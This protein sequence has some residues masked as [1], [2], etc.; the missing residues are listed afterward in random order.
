MKPSTE[1]EALPRPSGLI[2]TAYLADCLEVLPTVASWLQRQWWA[3][4]GGLAERAADRLRERAQRDRLPLTLVALRDGQPI[5]TVS[6]VHDH[7]PEEDQWVPC[8]GG[9]YV[10]PGWRRQG[11]G[12]L[13][14]ERALQE[15]ARLGLPRLFLYTPDQERFFA[16][17]GWDK[18]VDTL[19]R[20]GSGYAVVAWMERP[21]LPGIPAEPPG[22][23]CS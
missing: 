14:C 19:V 13:L 17:Q 8:L 12:A 21:V 6:L 18:I 16:N 3:A 11:V 23:R 7:P 5:G 22:R 15:A 20:V 9:I 4:G 2:Q 10:L 1:A